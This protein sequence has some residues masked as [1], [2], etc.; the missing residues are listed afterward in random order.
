MTMDEVETGQI[1]LKNKDKTGFKDVH[2]YTMDKE[3]L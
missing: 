3:I 1:Y 2:Y